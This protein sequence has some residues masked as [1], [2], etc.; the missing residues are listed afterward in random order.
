MACMDFL[1]EKVGYEY[2]MGVSGGAFKLLFAP[3]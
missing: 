1:E 3:G 2:L